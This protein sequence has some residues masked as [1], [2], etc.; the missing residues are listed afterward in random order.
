L[1][2]ITHADN[3]FR[4]RY[5]LEVDHID[6]KSTNHRANNLQFLTPQENSAR[7]NSR[8]CR[9]WEKGKDDAKIKYRSVTAAANAMGYSYMTVHRIL[10]NNTYKNWCG[11][12]I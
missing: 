1:R 2:K 8:P 10:T 11:E 5:Q 7:S 4:Y 9:I 12:Y 3:F 6:F